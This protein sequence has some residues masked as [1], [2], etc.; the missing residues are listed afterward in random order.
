MKIFDMH[1]H[2]WENDADV[3]NLLSAMDEA[4]VSGGCVFS[5][6]PMEY[7]V[8]L[9]RDFGV[10]L[11][12]VLTFCAAAPDRLYPILWVHPDEENVLEHIKLAAQRGILGYKIICNNF[13]IYEERCLEMMH[14]MAWLNKPV[15][16]HTGIL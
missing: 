6:P 16:F 11:E 14:L 12:E 8:N 7:D 10:R 15:I 9:G 1:I 4:G 5:R 13:F 2:L 3:K